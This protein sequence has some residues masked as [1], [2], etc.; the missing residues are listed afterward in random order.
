MSELAVPVSG[1]P[2]LYRPRGRPDR[3]ERPVTIRF[4]GPFSLLSPQVLLS[5]GVAMPGQ[6]RFVLDLSRV[7]RVLPGAL[8]ALAEVWAVVVAGGCSLS[9]AHGRALQPVTVVDTVDQKRLQ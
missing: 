9:L 1:A 3:S 5:L 6:S 2:D 8:E 7:S 4:F